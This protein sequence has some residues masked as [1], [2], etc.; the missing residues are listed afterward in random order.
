MAATRRQ[1]P[2]SR[3]GAHRHA[4]QRHWTRETAEAASA[5]VR[6]TPDLWD[7][8]VTKP[9]IKRFFTVMGGLVL[10][11]PAVDSGVALEQYV[12]AMIEK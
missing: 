5:L 1:G 2:P 3:D 4:H 7:R 12:Q 9:W 8:V 10:L 11:L 6:L